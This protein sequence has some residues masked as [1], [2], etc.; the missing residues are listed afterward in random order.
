MDE[1]ARASDLGAGTV[2]ADTYEVI[3]LLG[4]GGMGAVWEAHHRRLPGK[5]VAIKVLH[6]EVAGD[7]ESL[8]RF[9]R[10]AEIASRL[11]H[12]NIV[13]VHDFN[14]LPSGAP[15]LVLEFL[16]GES[17]DARIAR[18]ALSIDETI[19]IVRQIGSA[20]RAAHREG[21]VHRDLKPQNVFLAREGDDG[22][23]TKV[24]DF[25]ISKIRGSQTVKT[26]DSTMLGT[27][28]YMAPEQATGR[29]AEVD[30]RTDVFALGAMVY[31]MVCAAPAFPGQT[32]P[33]VVFKVVYQDPEPLAGKLPSAPSSVVEAIHKALAKDQAERFQ[34]VES[35][36]EALSGAPLATARRESVKPAAGS[37]GKD[38]PAA[39][40]TGRDA[41]AATVDSGNRAQVL[42]TDETMHSGQAPVVAPQPAA[43][44]GAAAEA[45]A[46]A[47]AA[48]G[49]STPQA[50]AKSAGS[51][52]RM[53]LAALVFAAVGAAAALA[54]LSRSGDDAGTETTGLSGERDGSSEPAFEAAERSDA[55]PIKDAATDEEGASAEGDAGAEQ[56]AEQ[57]ATG[58]ASQTRPRP[59]RTQPRGDPEPE[60]EE[61]DLPAAVAQDLSAAEAAI[62]AGD[63][64]AAIRAVERA[65]RQQA[66]V[67]GYSIKA[68]AYCAKH[69]LTNAR[70]SWRNLPPR[71]RQRVARFC[72]NFDIIL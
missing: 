64:D 72:A 33:E 15:Y 63:F 22:E 9:R 60:P 30:A 54:V 58:D 24:L 29:H 69:D 32:I 51:V 43:I 19:S 45:G 71:A 65:E 62:R 55:A 1:S 37:T 67:R 39:G 70:A 20:L 6:A 56:V 16:E 2:V 68:R 12:P 4:R 17:L 8:V 53:V 21:V 31:E 59:D 26:Q 14:T 38:A 61:E 47:V 50:H 27:P 10:E 57:P 5:K 42:G 7:H 40:S 3:R 28:Q 44:T 11:G 18:G 35:F 23:I 48:V 34:D 66:T 36:I 41:L 13:E 46:E 52:V 25:G 49:V